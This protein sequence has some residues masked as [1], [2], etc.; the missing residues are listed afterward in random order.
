MHTVD[1]GRRSCIAVAVKGPGVYNPKLKPGQLFNYD[2]GEALPEDIE[3]LLKFMRESRSPMLQTASDWIEEH[4]ETQLATFFV[5]SF[6]EGIQRAIDIL[7]ASHYR[8]VRPEQ[9]AEIEQVAEMQARFQVSNLVRG[10][11]VPPHVE[12]LRRPIERLLLYAIRHYWAQ[13]TKGLR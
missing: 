6:H 12:R 3:I 8:S 11:R 1:R 9:V 2:I 5:D 10:E 13:G 7:Q 4:P